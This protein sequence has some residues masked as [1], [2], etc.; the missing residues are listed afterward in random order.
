VAPNGQLDVLVVG[1]VLFLLEIVHTRST[2]CLGAVVGG[3][4]ADDAE[5]GQLTADAA[6]APTL[7]CVREPP[8]RKLDP[9]VTL[10]VGLNVGIVEV[11]QPLFAPTDHQP[12]PSHKTLAVVLP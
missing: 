11:V 10:M 2:N 5:I 4:V 12:R 7:L 8:C 6:V 1:F 3:L 9:L